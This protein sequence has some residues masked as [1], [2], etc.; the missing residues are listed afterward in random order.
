M[1]P[2]AYGADV[3]TD[4]SGPRLET[5]RLVLRRWSEADR[6]PFAAL[7]AD[8][9][10][11]RYFP[12]T[13][14]RRQSDAF[15]DRIEAGF[16]ADGFGLWALEVRGGAPFVGFTGIRRLPEPDP[17]AGN[18][19]VGWRLAREAWGHGYAVEAARASVAYGFDQAGL[20]EIVS[21]T[22]VSNGPSRTVMER[23]GM[24]HDPGEDFDHPAV[25]QDSPLCRHV[26]YRLRRPDAVRD[27][28]RRR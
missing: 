22:A 9:E 17:H 14:T 6:E 16:A 25:P 20:D 24:L 8:P 28:G 10:V 7:N 12:S 23:L 2:P 27:A 1:L 26:L 13:Q 19:E 11:M 5:T 3:Q 18:V 4:P 15:A 21:M